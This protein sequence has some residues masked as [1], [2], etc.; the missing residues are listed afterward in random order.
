V[1]H[2][3]SPHDYRTQGVQIA[4]TYFSPLNRKTA[5]TL[6]DIFEKL[7]Q[8]TRPH[9]DQFMVK[10]REINVA[11]AAKGIAR[12]SFAELCERAYGAEDYIEIAKRYNTVFLEGIPKLKYDRRNEAKRL[13]NLIDALYEA[14]VRV[15]IS[16]DTDPYKLYSGGDHSFEFERTISRLIEMQSEGYP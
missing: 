1:L 9:R 10:G 3:D 5:Q 7:I 11:Q 4:G 6:D 16:A 2:L 13:M 12:F 8:G 15:I 14:R